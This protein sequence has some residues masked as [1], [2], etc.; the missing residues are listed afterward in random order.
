MTSTDLQ[1]S[2]ID[3]LLGAKEVG[4]HFDWLITEKLLRETLTLWN[5]LMIERDALSRALEERG[6]HRV[7]LW[8]MLDERRMVAEIEQH[9]KAGRE[10][11]MIGAYLPLVLHRWSS[12]ITKWFVLRYG[13]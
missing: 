4:P 2:Q 8:N 7:I 12:R 3:R 13:K 10:M 11:A 9:K 6:D 5:L 1:V